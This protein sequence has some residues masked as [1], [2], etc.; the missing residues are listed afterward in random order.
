MA[1]L[2]RL[3]DEANLSN[4][5][6]FNASGFSGNYYYTRLRLEKPFT[7]DDL[8]RLATTLN[9]SVDVLTADHPQG[10]ASQAKFDGQKLAQRLGQL[11]ESADKSFSYV[12][13]DRELRRVGVSVTE[14]VWNG[15][16][17]GG[18]P[19]LVS[20]VTL[21]AIAEFFKVDPRYLLE[22]RFDDV[23]DRVEAELE[24]KAALREVGA[25]S[26]SSRALGAVSPE[27]LRAVAEAIRGR[28]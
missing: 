24:F 22:T 28:S 10:H 26:M 16:C 15:L 17:S 14:E 20:E 23:A 9:V 21:V 13:L 6:V 27:A 1:N 18:G 7:T 25:N 12:V 8:G 4:A 19:D 11:V 2:E 5:D 3:R